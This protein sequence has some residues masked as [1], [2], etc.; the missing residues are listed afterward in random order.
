MNRIF[1]FKNLLSL[2][3]LCT[4]AVATA[5]GLS[6]LPPAL[7]DRDPRSD[8]LR[9]GGDYKVEK[10]E[11][12]SD[13]TFVVE[14]HSVTATG[15][16]DVLRLESDHVHVAVKVGQTLRLSAEIL[17]D[18]GREAEVSQVVLFLPNPQGHVPV[19][20]LSNKVPAGELRGSKYL[21]MHSPL[22]DYVVM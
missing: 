10:I 14:F 5:E 12:V 16:Y 3:L 11:K 22:N 19:W 18:K 13:R 2:T 17:A 21:E 6:D 1:L 15:K 8:V 9:V 20:L 7:Q 4:S